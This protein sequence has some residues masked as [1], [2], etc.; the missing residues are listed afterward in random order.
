M[1][2][3]DTPGIGSAEADGR[4]DDQI[5]ESVLGE[6]DII[7]CV[8]VDDSIVNMFVGVICDGAN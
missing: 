8:I 2:L 5:A 6:S 7:C 4:T 3:I 1:R